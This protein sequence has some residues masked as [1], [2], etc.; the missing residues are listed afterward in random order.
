MGALLALGSAS[1]RTHR[2]VTWGRRPKRPSRRR[3]CASPVRGAARRTDSRP[4]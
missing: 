4:Y 3:P 2:E 1:S